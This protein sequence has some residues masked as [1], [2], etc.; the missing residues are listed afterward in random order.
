MERQAEEDEQ[1]S[2]RNDIRTVYQI[3]KKVA[4]STKASSGP[5]KANEGSLLSREDDKLNRWAE[6]FEEVLNRLSPTSAAVTSDPQ[7]SLYINTGYFTEEESRNAIEVLK[8][9]KSP[10][11]EDGITAEMLNG[12]EYTVKWMCQLRNQ[13]WNSGEVPDDWKTGA[14]VCIPKKGKNCW[15]GVTAGEGSPF[16]PY[17]EKSVFIDQDEVE[18]AEN[19]TYFGSSINNNGEMDKELKCRIGEA[20]AAF[21]QLGKI[22]SPRILT[23]TFHGNPGLTITVV[24]APTEAASP[25]DKDDFYSMLKD[26][27]DKVK[28]RDG[29]APSSDDKL[30]SEWRQYFSDLLN[31][32]SG[33][34]TS[35]LPPPAAQDLPICVEPPTLEE[36]VKAINSMKDNKAAG[37]DCA[38]TAEALRGGGDIMPLI[39]RVRQRQLG[40]I[41]HALR[42]PTEEP[43]RT[44]ALYIPT[45]GR[46]RPGRQ[47]TSYL[48]Y[49]QN[50]LGGAE[51]EMATD[52]QTWRRR[53]IG[54]CA[55]DR[56]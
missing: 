44:Y 32:D 2:A 10:G 15:L 55:T 41:G 3:T 13:V 21:N 34:Q 30:L 18:V 56:L 20:S 24:Y 31:N 46:R 22:W 52:R 1:A 39:N 54:R 14:V 16:C 51:G 29:S 28:K 40:F 8:N 17:Q 43:L 23:A 38:I 9:N 6:Y 7:Q 37:L 47:K 48:T 53:V 27:L 26:Q 45:H 25:A 11:M 36:T 35:V 19:V 42:L 33:P 4:D 5:I 50:L 49:I 12:G